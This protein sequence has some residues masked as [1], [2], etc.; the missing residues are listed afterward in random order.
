MNVVS[1]LAIVGLVLAAAGAQKPQ[2][3]GELD[4][5]TTSFHSYWNYS[6]LIQNVLQLNW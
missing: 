2:Q 3:C 1:A 4:L 5:Y 6:T